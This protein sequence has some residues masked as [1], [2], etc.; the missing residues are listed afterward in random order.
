MKN[1]QSELI[2]NSIYYD[3]GKYNQVNSSIRN[4][5]VLSNV[6]IRTCHVHLQRKSLFGE[7]Y[8]RKFDPH[9]INIT[10]QTD[11]T[12]SIYDLCKIQVKSS[13]LKVINFSFMISL[14]HSNVNYL[15]VCFSYSRQNLLLTN[16]FLQKKRFQRRDNIYN[17]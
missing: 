12:I 7:D 13:F 5:C 8:Q 6:C 1:K 14:F 9:N 16:K 3:S 15:S 17:I 4:I 2:Y 11:E 10:A